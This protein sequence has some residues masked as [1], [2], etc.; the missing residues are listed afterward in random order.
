LDRANFQFADVNG[1]GHADLLHKDKF[2]GDTQVW[3]YESQ[4]SEEERAGNS[5]SIIK[6]AR[7][8]K[9]FRGS[10]RGPDTHYPRLNNQGRADMVYAQATTAQVSHRSCFRFPVQ[11]RM[12]M[13]ITHCRLTSHSTCVPEEE[14]ETIRI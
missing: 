12:L 3:Y 14:T 11:Q 6:W 4:V 5:G 13:L 9:L 8:E 1:D 2:T 7:P 10:V